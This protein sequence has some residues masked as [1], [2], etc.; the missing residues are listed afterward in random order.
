MIERAEIAATA[1]YQVLLGSRPAEIITVLP[2]LNLGPVRGERLV[3]LVRQW[4]E[5]AKGQMRGDSG[6]VELGFSFGLTDQVARNL[7]DRSNHT[8]TARPGKPVQLSVRPR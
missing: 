8:T 3:E 6:S 5:A 7:G 4:V 2:R 1:Y